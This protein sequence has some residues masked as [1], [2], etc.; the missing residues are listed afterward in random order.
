MNIV[1]G[2]ATTIA[3]SLLC[4]IPKVVNLFLDGKCPSVLGGYIASTPLNPLVK[5]GAPAIG[6]TLNSYFEDFQF[7]VGIQ[8]GTEAI[9][10]LLTGLLNT[11]VI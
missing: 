2:A 10:L 5:V 6:K 3:D 9:L 1:G 4:S 7:R 8:G 11:K